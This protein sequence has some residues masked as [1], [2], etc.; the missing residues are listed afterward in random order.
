MERWQSLFYC[1]ITQVKSVHGIAAQAVDILVGE[2]E[3]LVVVEH[4]DGS[5]LHQQAIHFSVQDYAF[6]LVGGLFGT[7][8]KL[9][10]FCVV[11]PRVVGACR[12]AVRAIEKRQV[13]LGIGIVGNPTAAEPGRL[14][15]SY[16]FSQSG[17]GIDID[18]YL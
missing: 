16:L 8:V 12:T 9:V 10:V 7:A 5:L 14:A 17:R 6:L 3:Y 1:H 18:F 2:M 13:V 15:L 11:V 4:H